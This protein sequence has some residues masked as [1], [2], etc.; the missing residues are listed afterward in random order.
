[1]GRRTRPLLCSESEI[2][3][4]EALA[5]DETNPRLA[6][7]ARMILECAKGQQIKDVAA[8]FSERPNTV[9]LWKRRYEEAGI[10]GL[11]NAPRGSTKDVYGEPFVRR[12]LELLNSPPP[13]GRKYWTG[14]LLADALGT[15]HDTI[16][17]YLRKKKI[18]LLE[19]RRH[20]V[21]NDSP[22]DAED[23]TPAPEEVSLPVERQEDSGIRRTV[24][25]ESSSPVCGNSDELQNSDLIPD[26]PST[27][28]SEKRFSVSITGSGDA[29]ESSNRPLDVYIQVRVMDGDTCVREA[30]SSFSGALPDLGQIEVKIEGP[31]KEIPQGLPDDQP[32]PAQPD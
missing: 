18:R 11:R 23:S 8:M 31:S 2:L 5:A 26:S 10:E 16:R 13:D 20:L 28:I 3:A 7:R 15:P 12:L 17:R 25:D 30:L 32:G 19:Y 6:L 27:T 22:D 29:R 1:M 21:E 4:L 9:I 14:P 24:A